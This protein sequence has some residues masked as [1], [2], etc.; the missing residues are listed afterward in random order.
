M[1]ALSHRPRRPVPAGPGSGEAGMTI[2]V[3]GL[4]LTALLITAAIV[5]YVGALYAARLTWVSGAPVLAKWY[6][7]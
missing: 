3:M 1:A 7:P 4:I 5:I 6:L 2:V